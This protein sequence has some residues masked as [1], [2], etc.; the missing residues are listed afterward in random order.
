MKRSRAPLPMTT[1]AVTALGSLIAAGRRQRG[2]TAAELGERLGVSAPTVTRIEK[3]DPG[4]AV[5]TVFEAALLVGVRLFD[6]EPN[7]LARVARDAEQRLAL[8][9]SRVRVPAEGA[10]GTEDSDGLDF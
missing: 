4:V 6:V 3:G 5:G 7:E 10:T 2:W 1:R 8:L 9:P